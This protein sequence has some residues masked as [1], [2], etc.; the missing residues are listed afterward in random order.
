MKGISKQTII[1]NDFLMYVLKKP[2]RT[3]TDKPESV[4][5][6]VYKIKHIFKLWKFLGSTTMVKSESINILEWGLG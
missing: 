3:I 6:L 5:V 1:S 2:Q 4:C